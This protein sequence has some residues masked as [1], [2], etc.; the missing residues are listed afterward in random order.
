MAE[1]LKATVLKIV[2]GV[3][4]SRV[5]IPVPPPFYIP[6]RSTTW[7]C[8]ARRSWNVRESTFQAW[9][10]LSATGDC[11]STRSPHGCSCST[12]MERL[13][14][15]TGTGPLGSPAHA[16]WLRCSGGRCGAACLMRNWLFPPTRFSCEAGRQCWFALGER[17]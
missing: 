15:L 9:S 17:F 14:L 5:R 12:P 3:T 8:E 6:S 1:R 13:R 2:S 11:S 4:R 16:S 10:W 7:T